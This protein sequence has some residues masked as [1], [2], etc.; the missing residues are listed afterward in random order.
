MKGRFSSSTTPKPRRNPSSHPHQRSA[1]W[2]S[3]KLN[4]PTAT[5]QGPTTTAAARDEKAQAGRAPSQLRA[6]PRAPRVLESAG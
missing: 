4:H 2:A 5:T 1:A 6:S 3:R